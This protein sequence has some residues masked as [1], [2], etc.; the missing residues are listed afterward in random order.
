M[1][2]GR[3][4]Q[5]G[6][7]TPDRTTLI[8]STNRVYAITERIALGD[9][10]T[11]SEQ[12]L[13]GA[14]AGSRR[15]IAADFS[16]LAAEAG[17]V[18]SASLFG[19][20]AGSG[21]LPFA[22]EDFEHALRRSGKAVQTSMA[23]FER[24]YEAAREPAPAPGRPPSAALFGALAGSGALP[25]GREQFEAEIQRFGKGAEASLRAFAAGY[26]AAQQPAAPAARRWRTRRGEERA[27]RSRRWRRSAGRR[28]R[29]T[30]SE[31]RIR[32]ARRAR[33]SSRSVRRRP[34]HPWRGSPP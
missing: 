1:E 27:R 6:F 31:R 4:I 3:A 24:G 34:R 21:E 7:C 9:G 12:L 13:S 23:A 20:L 2:A 16:R 17:S 5:R 26:D 30:C 19:A 10:R 29:P 11:D 22:R 28:R 25:F 32:P 14:R 15:L 8:A 18:I 33:L